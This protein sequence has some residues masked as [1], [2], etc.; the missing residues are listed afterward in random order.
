MSDN[1]PAEL[2]TYLEATAEKN[3]ALIVDALGKLEDPT[4]RGKLKITVA[5]VCKLT[6]LSRN[7]VRNRL[8]ALDRLKALKLKLKN[9]QQAPASGA[10][11]GLSEGAIL[12][13]LRRRVKRALEQ[14]ALLFEEISSL[15]SIIENKDKVIATLKARKSASVVS[16]PRRLEI[17]KPDLNK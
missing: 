12:D 10:A 14:N 1:R 17:S 7:T 5:S 3:D 6:G 4:K 13:E 11:E 8:W 9:V 15:H 2:N 16:L